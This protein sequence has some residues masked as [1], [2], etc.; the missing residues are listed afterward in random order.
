[1]FRFII[2]ILCG[3]PLLVFCIMLI[4]MGLKNYD[5]K[6]AEYREFMKTKIDY[7][8]LGEKIMLEPDNGPSIDESVK[9]VKR[10]LEEEK[11]C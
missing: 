8:K 5:K 2:Y 7:F 4:I 9:R 11:P 3:V 1:M 6:D 10:K